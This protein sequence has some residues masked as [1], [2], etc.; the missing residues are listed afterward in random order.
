MQNL[1]WGGASGEMK[2][3]LRPEL[4]LFVGSCRLPRTLKE[5]VL[6][7]GDQTYRDEYDDPS[8]KK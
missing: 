7:K 8:R 4:K 6:A 2:G 1:G 5:Q 3:S